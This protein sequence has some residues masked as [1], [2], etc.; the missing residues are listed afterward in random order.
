MNECNEVL[1]RARDALAKVRRLA[2]VVQHAMFNGDL[3]RASW[4]LQHL[5]TAASIE[6]GRA[7]LA[8]ASSNSRPARS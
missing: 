1:D 2:L 4:G 8:P 7:A 6:V 5:Q 3:Q